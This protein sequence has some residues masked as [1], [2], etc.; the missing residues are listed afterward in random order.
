[1]VTVGVTGVSP[2]WLDQLTP[3]GFVLAP[4]WH[5]GHHPVLRVWRDPDGRVGAAGFCTAGFMSAAGPL[6]ATYPGMH[7][8]TVGPLPAPTVTRPAR[9]DPPLGIFDYHDL[10]FAIGT[11]DRRATVARLGDN[12][13]GCVLLDESGAGGAMVMAD[14]AV[15]ASG[16]QA[17]AYAVQ[18]DALVDR[19]VTDGAPR[20]SAW[21]AEMALDGDPAAP[22]WVPRS[23][24]LP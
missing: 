19:W 8:T 17:E 21:R 16:D 11:W 12:G 18:A 13:S 3:D 23:W 6:G 22:I 10:W 1:V 24:R 15:R 5:A 14:G 9:F 2:H 4:V 7:P 20:M